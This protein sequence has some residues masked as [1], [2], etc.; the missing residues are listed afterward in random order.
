MVGWLLAAG[1]L[2][3]FVGA[4]VTGGCGSS[5]DGGV[6]IAVPTRVE[7]IR[8]KVHTGY[9]KALVCVDLNR[10]GR[11]DAGEP[12]AMS[13]ADGA[14]ELAA[15][16]GVVVPL[17]A[18]VTAGQSLVSGSASSVSFRLA[19]P[20]AAYSTAIT[21]LTTLLLL[22]AQTDSALAED[23]AREVLG[24][25][26]GYEVNWTAATQPAALAQRA[27]D[28]LLTALKAHAMQAG[29][30]EAGLT[31][32]GALAQVVAAF[33]PALANLPQLR[34]KT[35]DGAPIVSKEIYVDATYVLSNPLAAVHDVTLKG[36]IRGR[37]HST[38]GLP[39]NPYKVQF[40]NDAAYAAIG[41]VLGMKKQ[42]NW[43]LLADYFD[44][45]LMRNKLALTLGASSA[46]REGL[47]WTPAG[48]HVEVFLN[49]DY[50]GVYL[51][52][53]DIRLDAARL[54]L[55][56]MNSDP[57][58][59][60]VEGGYIVEADA[61]LDCY[62]GAD[63]NLQLVTPRGVQICIDTP[64]EEAI[65]PAQLAYIKN[66]LTNAEA[67]IY[68]ARSL[69]AIDL[70]S[71]A[72]WYLLQELFRN[73][74]SMFYTSVFMWKDSSTALDPRDRRLNLG[75][76]WDFDRSAGNANYNDAWQVEGCWVAKAY[77][78]NWLAAL[79]DDP[80]FLALTL[81]R[82]QQKRPAIAAYID[83]SV[84]IQA[85]RLEA[86]QQRNFER[87]PIFGVTLTNY[88]QFANYAEETA[89]LRNYLKAR[90]TWLDQA[91]AS[92]D[93]FQAMCK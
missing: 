80:R 48:Q 14:Y 10:S 1:V 77:R 41:D 55:H 71:F 46:F 49:E 28:E 31:S 47:K 79:L 89:F 45:S 18:E 86:A 22:T 6:S 29:G 9:V 59:G 27:A 2:A 90:M 11:C 60:D 62:K 8:G 19:S 75:P 91:Y 13:G 63:L 57:T 73:V 5:S 84:S 32:P 72:D 51:L 30:T 16:V 3:S 93:A 64:D 88:Y 92:P 66:L 67:D 40:S 36:K 50:V 4:A 15:P 25:P 56:K 12:S 53:E 68:G 23:L 43:A 39:K 85:Q 74:D 44:R 87:W 7:T 33:P 69:D 82:W 37:G 78:P 34:I 21:P 70:L 65:T 24:L 52:T 38:W 17:I 54:P 35:K 83:A 26:P 61:R 76:L 20:S 81:S 58:A 42:R